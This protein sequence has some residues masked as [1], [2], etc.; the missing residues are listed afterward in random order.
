MTS[1]YNILIAGVGGQGNLVCGRILGEAAMRMNLRPVIGDTFGAPRRGGTVYTHL[2][3]GE[4][5]VGPLIPEREANL[6]LGLE[7]METLRAVVKYGGEK[8]VILFSTQRVETGDSLAG[9]LTYPSV[10]ELSKALGSISEE[11]YALNP[12]E[13]LDELGTTRVLNSYMLGALTGLNRTPLERNEVREL[14]GKMTKP[15]DTNLAAFDAGLE[16]LSE[17]LKRKEN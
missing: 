10:G 4:H 14:V 17:L 5:P 3:I 16:D 13:R 7:P 12:K 11:V 6:V 9:N 2:R 8:T 1:S 15:S